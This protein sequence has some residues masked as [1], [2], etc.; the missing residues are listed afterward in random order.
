MYELDFDTCTMVDVI[1]RSAIVHPTLLRDTMLRAAGLHVTYSGVVANGQVAKIAQSMASDLQLM[2]DELSNGDFRPEDLQLGE[3]V[4]AFSAACE[5]Q[6]ITRHVR[7]AIARREADS[8]KPD[9]RKI[10]RRAPPR[11]GSKAMG[12]A[13]FRADAPRRAFPNGSVE[14]VT[15]WMGGPSLAQINHCPVKLD[16]QEHPARTAYVQGEADTY[17]SIPAAICVKGK[18]V[19]GFVMFETG[20]GFTFYNDRPPEEESPA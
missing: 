9:K 4:Q 6:G 8:A 1:R 12:L 15:L 14:Y 16:G 13:K 18:R 7:T 2:A 11:E 20:Q 3:R 19:P 5:L 10:V 17:F